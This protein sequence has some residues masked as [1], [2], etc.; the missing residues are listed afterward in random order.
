MWFFKFRRA[1]VMREYA[2]IISALVI[3]TVIQSLTETGIVRDLDYPEE[4]S[5]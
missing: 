4:F 5:G 3:I 2:A 1:L